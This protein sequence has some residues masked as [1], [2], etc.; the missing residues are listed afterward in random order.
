MKHIKMPRFFVGINPWLAFAL[1]ALD[2]LLLKTLHCHY[3][4]WFLA[5]PQSFMV[6]Y[7]HL[8]LVIWAIKGLFIL[9]FAMCTGWLLSMNVRSL[10]NYLK[11]HAT[12]VNATAVM[13]AYFIASTMLGEIHPFSMIPMYQRIRQHADLFYLEDAQGKVI[14]LAGV[15]SISSAFINKHF[16]T[17]LNTERMTMDQVLVDTMALKRAGKY[18]F[19]RSISLERLVASEHQSARMVILHCTTHSTD[20]QRFVIYEYN[21]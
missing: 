17:F 2:C 20:C 18:V 1:L 14:P 13:L 4:W 3:K 21:K 8:G 19:D 12:P 11:K 16:D 15:G 9:A 6:W 5:G 7:E 10:F